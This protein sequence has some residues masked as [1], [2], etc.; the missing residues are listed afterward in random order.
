MASSDRPEHGAT[1]PPP[2]TPASDD[3]HDH[4]PAHRR[5]R[6]G[7]SRTPDPA[8][9]ILLAGV[10][11][12]ALVR[13]WGLRLPR[14]LVLVS[15]LIGSAYAA[16]HALTACVTKPL[17]LLAVEPVHACGRRSAAAAAVMAASSSENCSTERGR[18]ARV[19]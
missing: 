7:R 9:R 10:G 14:W 1:S 2:D 3:D 15:A 5:T 4:E 13:P 19:G 8:D 18:G 6:R 17:D 12:L 16:G 11:A